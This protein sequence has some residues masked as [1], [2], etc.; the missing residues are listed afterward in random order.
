MAFVFINHKVEDYAT[1]REGFDA[2]ES[3]RKE[4]GE[5]SASVCTV[6]GEPNTV[7]A[8]IQFGSMEQA[9]SFMSAPDLA[10]AMKEAGV[11]GKP[12]V[13]FLNPT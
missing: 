12:D 6:D 10:N 13:T 1:W 11:I 8:L 3:F 9:K 2:H 4:G 7:A 5:V